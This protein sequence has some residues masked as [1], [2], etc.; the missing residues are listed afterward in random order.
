VAHPAA[1]PE[2]RSPSDTAPQAFSPCH[3]RPRA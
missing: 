1:E 3:H 2:R